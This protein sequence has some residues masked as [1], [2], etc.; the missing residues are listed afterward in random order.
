MAS[1]G[2]L[3]SFNTAALPSIWGEEGSLGQPLLGGRRECGAVRTHLSSRS[4][5]VK[6]TVPAW[7]LWQTFKKSILS[8]SGN[9]DLFCFAISHGSQE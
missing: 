6:V 4:L 9:P 2:I 8:L 7:L 3:H 5:P 1:G